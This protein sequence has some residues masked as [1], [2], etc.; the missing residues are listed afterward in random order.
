M[1][2]T[3]NLPTWSYI[4][5]DATMV[6]L[7]AWIGVKWFPTPKVWTPSIHYNENIQKNSKP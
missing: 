2:R 6:G 1:I 7:E 5:D 4:V 3:Q